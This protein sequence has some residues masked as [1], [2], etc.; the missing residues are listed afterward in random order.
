LNFKNDATKKLLH[1]LDSVLKM[2]LGKL[3]IAFSTAQELK[4]GV[5][6]AEYDRFSGVIEQ[7]L[8]KN[9]CQ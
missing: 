8:V 3:R 1:E 9:N 4:S 2:D 5:D 7:C 6:R